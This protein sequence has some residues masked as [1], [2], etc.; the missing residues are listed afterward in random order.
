MNV[1]SVAV[2]LLLSRFHIDQA[3]LA[4]V[5]MVRAKFF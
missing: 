2:I 5:S 3:L 4:Q 1:I